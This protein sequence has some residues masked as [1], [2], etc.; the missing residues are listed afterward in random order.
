MTLYYAVLRTWYSATYTA[1]VELRG[2]RGYF[3][4]AVPVSRAIPSAEMVAGRTV[5]ILTNEPN[6]VTAMI[7]VAVR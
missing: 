5:W 2:G 3:L 4:A 6:N 7:I 1:D